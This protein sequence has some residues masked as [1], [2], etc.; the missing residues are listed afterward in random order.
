M[1]AQEDFSDD[2]LTPQPNQRQSNAM[3]GSFIALLLLVGGIAFLYST[4]LAP[5]SLEQKWITSQ[6]TSVPSST[7]PLTDSTE[8]DLQR[9][10]CY[11]TCPAY[12]LKIFGSGRVEFYGEAFVCQKTPNPTFINPALVRQLID[13]LAAVN[14]FN[15]PSYTSYDVTDNPS[16]II[17][18]N[19]NGQ[20]HRVEHY[21]GDSKAPRL[22][23]LIET[24]IDDIA[25]TDTWIGGC[26]SIS[27]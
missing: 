23:T 24:R 7:L 26:D 1:L 13:G 19:T 5:S 16:A 10:Q 8:I 6:Q 20:S 4:K 15:M 9:T 27:R 22:L 12:R 21:F 11:G 25:N 18:V 2:D 14:F 3:I 17:T